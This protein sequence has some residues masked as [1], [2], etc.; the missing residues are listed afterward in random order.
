MRRAM[1]KENCEWYVPPGIAHSWR[2][3][4]ERHMTLKTGRIVATN[5]D[6]SIECAILN[7]S[8]HGACVLLPAGATAGDRFT[9]Y[10]DGD[11]A[12]HACH[13]AWRDGP[14]IGVAYDA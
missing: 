9:L 8:L 5:H 1:T 2:R 14:R 12:P 11:D 7:V 6:L 13:V 10:I 3:R 4:S